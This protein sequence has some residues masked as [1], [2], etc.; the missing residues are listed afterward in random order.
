MVKEQAEKVQENAGVHGGEGERGIGGINLGR[1]GIAEGL[2]QLSQLG[3][4]V[5]RGVDLEKLRADILS[6]GQSA[7]TDL[8]NTVAPPISEHETLQV[9]LAHEMVGYDGVTGV[10]E[11]GV[12]RILEQTSSEDL[13]VI[14][15]PTPKEAPATKE[16]PAS[17]S[18]GKEEKTTSPRSSLDPSSFLASAT[19]LASQ[20]QNRAYAED[21]ERTIN[22]VQGWEEGWKK[23]E[24]GVK[25]LVERAKVDSRRRGPDPSL[26]V[27]TIPLYIHIQPV[28]VPLA[29]SEPP[30]STSVHRDSVSSPTES[31]SRSLN[32][33]SASTTTTSDSKP[34]HLTFILSLS[35]TTHSLRFITVT[36]YSPADWL[37]VEYDRSDWVEERLVAVLKTGIEGLL[38]EYVATRMGLKRASYNPSAAVLHTPTSTNRSSADGAAPSATDAENTATDPK[39]P[40]ETAGT[41][42]G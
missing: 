30:I 39:V 9:W 31:L 21:E 16:E 6:R 4:G 26:P 3:A 7:I 8:I 14:F 38:Q 27:T 29:F 22:P 17:G 25:E 18:P 28:L 33:A 15:L 34:E 42:S 24:T 12:A 41:E 1:L 10:V 32:P 2:G 37:E 23:A 36:Q 5:V 35:D 20:F 13:E 40:N 11:S 19:A